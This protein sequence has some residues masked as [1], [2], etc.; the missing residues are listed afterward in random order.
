MLRMRVGDP[1]TVTRT[2]KGVEVRDPENKA[3]LRAALSD[4]YP[5]TRL[6][7]LASDPRFVAPQRH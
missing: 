5:L 1:L 2:E 6:R 7:I 4:F 3:L